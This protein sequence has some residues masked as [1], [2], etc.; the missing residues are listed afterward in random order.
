[1]VRGSMLD[2]WFRAFHFAS[3]SEK[4]L[5]SWRARAARCY[6]SDL[7]ACA[8]PVRLT[9]LA[10]L[11]WVRTGE[12][13]DSL[14]DLLIRLVHKINARAELRVGGT[15]SSTAWGEL[16]GSPTSSASSGPS[17]MPSV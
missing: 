12:I 14:L 3:T 5:S 9:L 16:S 10:S 2:T 1:M 7:R 11:C 13:T 17:A 8:S 15:P 6:P 4:L